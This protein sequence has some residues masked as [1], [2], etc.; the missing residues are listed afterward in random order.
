MGRKIYHKKIEEA[1][2]YLAPQYIKKGE[3]IDQS[4]L[5]QIESNRPSSI[6]I[7]LGGGVQ[8]RLGLYL[9]DNLSY[10]RFTAREQL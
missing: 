7:Q 4:L 10:L 3:I 8:E 5:S 9:K 1:D 2:I 6:F